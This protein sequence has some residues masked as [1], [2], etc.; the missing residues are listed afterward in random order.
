MSWH[1]LFLSS[2]GFPLLT[3]TSKG[4]LDSPTR[5]WASEGERK[6]TSTK[7][8]VCFGSKQEGREREG[9]LGR[10]TV[11]E[12]EGK[13]VGWNLE[14]RRAKNVGRYRQKRTETRQSRQDKNLTELSQK[15]HTEWKRPGRTKSQRKTQMSAASGEEGERG[16]APSGLW[17]QGRQK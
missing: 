13:R 17:S 14:K 9:S 16:S 10:G 8:K 1:S 15:R 5:A 6:G 11:C 12:R 3:Q 7:Q 4:T 2:G